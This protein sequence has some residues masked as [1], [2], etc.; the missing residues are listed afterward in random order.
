[1][2]H[3]NPA[4]HGQPCIEADTSQPSAHASEDHLDLSQN[5]D[6]HKNSDSVKS[7]SRVCALRHGHEGKITYTP[8]PRRVLYKPNLQQAHM[9][10]ML[11][12]QHVSRSGYVNMFKAAVVSADGLM[13]GPHNGGT[14]DFNDNL[15]EL[16]YQAQ[17]HRYSTASMYNEPDCDAPNYQSDS[18]WQSHSDS[19]DNTMD[20]LGPDKFDVDPMSWDI[21]RGQDLTAWGHA[22]AGVGE[23]LVD[24][25]QECANQDELVVHY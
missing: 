14:G 19:R 22:L 10:Q 2:S 25:Y 12:P 1:M 17:S 5:G 21:G 4:T 9:S 11:A 18:H 6:A 7:L 23:H 20:L 3:A 16:P 15:P 24:T 13:R 8:L